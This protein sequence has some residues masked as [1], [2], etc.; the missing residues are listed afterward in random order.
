[1]CPISMNTSATHLLPRNGPAIATFIFVSLRDK[2]RQIGLISSVS[3]RSRT[4]CSVMCC[5]VYYAAGY[6][7]FNRKSLCLLM[8]WSPCQTQ[9]K[10]KANKGEVLNAGDVMVKTVGCLINPLTANGDFAHKKI[11]PVKV[12]AIIRGITAC[13]A[14]N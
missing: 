8:R 4:E 10:G 12:L 11:Y 2:K 3:S 14:K 9:R 1:M 6:V 5:Q 13:G 7:Y